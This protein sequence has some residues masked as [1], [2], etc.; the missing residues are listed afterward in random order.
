MEKR[1]PWLV[2]LFLLTATCWT[3]AATLAA[4]ETDD[5]RVE[6]RAAGTEAVIDLVKEDNES[7]DKVTVT[8]SVRDGS[9]IAVYS[10]EDDEEGGSEQ[11][12]LRNQFHQLFEYT[13]ENDNEMYDDG[14]PIHSMWLLFPESQPRVTAPANGTLAWEPWSL[15]DAESDDGK[16][17]KHLQAM[18]LF[19]VTERPPDLPDLPGVEP[20]VEEPGFVKIDLYAFGDEVTYNTTPLIDT[21]VFVEF[22]L[23]RYPYA[24]E[25]TRLALATETQAEDKLEDLGVKAPDGYDGWG[26][27]A[28]IND[29]EVGLAFLWDQDAD[30]DGKDADVK[31]DVV[32]TRN[33]EVEDEGR[34]YSEHMRLYTLNY[35]RPENLTH[36]MRV[37]A[38]LTG[39]LVGDL[40]DVGGDDGG[41]LPGF[42]AWTVVAAVAAAGLAVANKRRTR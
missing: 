13:D 12:N 31:H 38:D 32:E 16:S 36:E 33:E 40:I 30:E 28:T 41:F 9:L 3:A 6:A 22:S 39:L 2:G 27:G 14:E 34:R 11:K 1:T 21:E 19:P 18:G 8:S 20:M 35:G 42:A 10:D 7:D 25:G 4:E 23:A 15:D 29:Q 37:G 26:T 17:G 5:R 24:E